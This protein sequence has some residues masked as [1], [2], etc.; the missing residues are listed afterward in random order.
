MIYIPFGC[1]SGN[2]DPKLG[3]SH[4]IPCLIAGKLGEIN[5]P[6]L[7]I[8]AKLKVLLQGKIL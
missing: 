6:P 4:Y 5:M 8:Q 7:I 3:V 1:T 2:I